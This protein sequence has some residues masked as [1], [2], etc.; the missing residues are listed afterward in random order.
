[1]TPEQAGH[2]TGAG[3]PIIFTPVAKRRPKIVYSTCGVLVVVIATLSAAGGTD[4][5]RTSIDIVCGVLFPFWGYRRIAK[6]IISAA[7]Q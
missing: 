5:L 1:M 4:S 6:K 7:S 2:F 3:F